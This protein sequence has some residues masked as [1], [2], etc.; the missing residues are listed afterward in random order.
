[1]TGMI[2]RLVA[3]KIPLLTKEGCPR[4]CEG[5]VVLSI[6]FYSFGEDFRS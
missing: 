5:G 3:A 4:L 6:T 1:M 2:Q